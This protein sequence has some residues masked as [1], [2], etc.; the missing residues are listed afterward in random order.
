[1]R[2]S[3]TTVPTLLLLFLAAVACGGDGGS[4]DGGMIPDPLP[5]FV[6]DRT[7]PAAND[8]YLT[9]TV[10]SATSLQ[11]E[12]RVVVPDWWGLPNTFVGRLRM[13]ITALEPLSIA[14]NFQWPLFTSGQ[15]TRALLVPTA[16]PGD[17]DFVVGIEPVSS[18]C[19]SVG[20]NRPADGRMMVATVFVRIKQAGTYRIELLVHSVANRT[21]QLCSGNIT[22]PLYGGTLT[23]P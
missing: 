3:S 14:N 4:S 6:P 19:P 8:I 7:A 9:A 10:A 23:V 18:P 1:M 15:T 17:W 16:T 2:A 12:I 20:W 22:T 21:V 5:S 13:P 11:L